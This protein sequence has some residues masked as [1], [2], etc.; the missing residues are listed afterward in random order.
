M[1]RKVFQGDLKGIPLLDK[2][3]YGSG[4]FGFGIVFQVL[5]TYLVFYTT[6]VLHI[7]G[8][9]IGIAVSLSIIW[10]GVTDPLMGYVSDQTRMR[11]FGRRHLYIL[12]GSIG[13]AV[14]NY[15]LWIIDPAFGLSTKIF[16]VLLSV[17][18]IR[19]FLT[20]CTVPYTALGAELSKDYDERSSIQGIR[21][22]FFLSG[23]FVATVM[24]M[25]LFFQPTLEFPKGQLNPEAYRNIGLTSSVCAL[26]FGFICYFATKK[27]IPY[28]PKAAVR[29]DKPVFSFRTLAGEVMKALH[30]KDYKYI[31]LGYLF[32]NITSALIGTIGLHV[33]TYTF[34]FDN[35]GIAMIIGIQFGLSILSQPF[36]VMISKAVDKQP[37]VK[38]GLAMTMAGALYFVFLVLFREAV[39]ANVLFFIP[40]ALLSG[41]GIGGLFSLPLSMIADTI[42]VEE[43]STGQRNEGIY[44]GCLTLC[45]KMAQSIAIFLLGVVLDIIRFD[46]SLI[47]QPKTT[48]L[49]LGLILSVGSVISLIF[50]YA[51]YQR[52][53]L[54]KDTISAVQ[55]S[56]KSTGG[57][58]DA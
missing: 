40:F 20:I 14:F 2:I 16:G 37:A 1:G 56:I 48:A 3:Y 11:V 19:T 35:V 8:S 42:D 54:N 17:L 41:F 44:Y 4:N 49:A 39:Q 34:H 57:T 15:F 22:I 51:A 12:L 50:A 30:N 47:I 46:S 38:L 10:D 6:A 58:Y 36:W 28:L 33:F 21:T 27:Y 53:S 24:G 52:Y 25:Y 31:V 45:Y 23:L 43:L 9:I 7:P 32:T 18:L 55:R 13:V 29:E 26:I 5:A